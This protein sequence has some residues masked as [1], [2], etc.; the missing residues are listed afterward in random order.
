M[1]RRGIAQ[2][3]GSL[4]A[5]KK[6]AQ[7]NVG[8][9]RK[10]LAQIFTGLACL[11]IAAQKALNRIGHILRRAA[12]AD[13]P[14]EAGMFSDSASQTEIVSILRTAIRFDLLA[15]QTDNG[16]AMLAAT[17]RAPGHIEFQLLI[18]PR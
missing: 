12:I 11:K 7:S 4:L 13:G 9:T 8:V 16:N 5:C 18:K 3:G 1:S 17:V 10:K 2:N 6:S 15:F 14:R